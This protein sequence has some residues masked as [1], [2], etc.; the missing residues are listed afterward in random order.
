MKAL[1]L[2][3]WSIAVVVAEFLLTPILERNQ[4]R[5]G[6]HTRW[7]ISSTQVVLLAGAGAIIHRIADTKIPVGH[8]DAIIFALVVLLIYFK[9]KLDLATPAQAI[10][11]IKTLLQRQGIGEVADFEPHQWA[12]GN[13]DEG[14]I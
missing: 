8:P 2:K 9:R 11:L 10:D 14:I 7:V 4:L 6:T 1:A 12:T 3:L 5:K 13:P